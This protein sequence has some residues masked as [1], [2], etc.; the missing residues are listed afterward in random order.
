ML[1]GAA[2]VSPL[3]P[4]ALSET[5]F[6]AVC[7]ALVKAAVALGGEKLKT[8]T[9]KSRI[10]TK[11]RDVALQTFENIEP[12]LTA[13]GVKVVKQDFLITSCL[14]H[15]KPLLKKPQQFY[16]ASLSGEKLRNQ[17]FGKA[18][19][20]QEI[21][22]ENLAYPFQ[23][24][25]PRV[26]DLFCAYLPLVP[27]L[28]DKEVKEIF[29]R[30]D[31]VQ[32]NHEAIYAQLTAIKDLPLKGAEHHFHQLHKLTHSEVVGT[33]SF[34]GLHGM[35]DNEI[36]LDDIFV[37]PAIV[38]THDSKLKPITDEPATL[39]E[40]CAPG[41]RSFIEGQPGA[42]KTTWT[43]WLQRLV[44][45]Q[46]STLLAFRLRF[47]EYPQDALPSYYDLVRQ[48]AGTH[49]AAKI[50]DEQI[51]KWIEAGRVVFILDGF[52]EVAPA[53][54][55]EICKWMTGLA[56]N[57]PKSAILVTSRPLS[58]DHLTTLPKRWRRWSIAAF[59]APRIEDYIRRWYA[60]CPFAKG[61]VDAAALAQQ[62]SGDRTL[63]DLT[64]NP[65]M[66]GTLLAVHN[67]ESQQL[68][69]GRAK[70]YE[71]Y[72]EGML[73]LWEKRIPVQRDLEFPYDA[74]RKL[75]QHFA[76]WF[77]QNNT[78]TVGEEETGG[79]KG[80]HDLV[81]ELLS[82]LKLKPPAGAAKDFAPAV[83]AEL[84]ERTGM[85]EGPGTYAFVHKSVAEYL[86][87]VAVHDGHLRTIGGEPLDRHWLFQRRMEDR[88]LGVLYFWAG[89]ATIQ[90]L[91]ALIV[92]S[93]KDANPKA[94][95]LELA[96]LYDQLDRLP[97]DFVREQIGRIVTSEGPAQGGS[98]HV[99]PAL[100]LPK[101]YAAMLTCNAWN[102]PAL[103]MVSSV[104]TFREFIV[105]IGEPNFSSLEFIPVWAGSIFFA[106]FL[107]IRN[108][109]SLRACIKLAEMS[110]GEQ[111]DNDGS[112]S[113]FTRTGP[114]CVAITLM[115]VICRS[116][117]RANQPIPF[118]ELVDVLSHR[119][120]V[121]PPLIPFIA[122]GQLAFMVID[123]AETADD[124][125][126]IV[127]FLDS[128]LILIRSAPMNRHILRQTHFCW[129]WFMHLN[130]DL[131]ELCQRTLN[132]LA[133]EPNTAPPDAVRRVREYVE[134][135][136]TERE[137]LWS[138]HGKPT[139]KEV[140]EGTVPDVPPEAT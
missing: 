42:G 116:A 39:A 84:R 125:S 109:E 113:S 65:L 57:A 88:W 8:W 41:A 72:I 51:D 61:K 50:K 59:D 53:R 15:I 5:V 13:E 132:H 23:L 10:E 64:G 25:F 92:D 1:D 62:W 81:R 17:L 33:L 16:S 101:R 21:I 112:R 90:N 120:P 58:T 52:D 111:V 76:L 139:Q 27:E 45:A 114:D 97:K 74:K 106:R 91:E 11:L 86:F 137:R 32:K 89:S 31:E 134:S 54:R 44:L 24:V 133:E 3:S 46:I 28:R 98:T 130:Y 7:S 34:T 30:F 63:A 102:L 87:A 38:P 129:V 18:G 115:S 66:L 105:E 108:S 93:G 19:A 79:K 6:K 124:I 94:R 48:R 80:M 122:L 96:L 131:L 95:L 117:I 56:E 43:G 140:N 123:P 121:I 9:L 138:L 2:E 127:I 100:G 35:S 135:L 12:L 103:R 60:R 73:D 68:P 77:L 69:R 29:V 104:I 75:L 55:E 40:L 26:A 110:G 49:L 128:A 118:A 37:L 67:R 107:H 126:R 99:W 70:L 119:Y 4:M 22:D 20:P 82:D 85:L 71:K 14:A 36:S 136:L 47:R 78:L 83:L